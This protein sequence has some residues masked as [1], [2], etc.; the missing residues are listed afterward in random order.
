[1]NIGVLGTGSVGQALA[2]KFVALGHPVRM[3]A[4]EAG[5][6]KAADWAAAA[7]SGASTGT[8]ADAAAFGEL[9]INATAGV[10]SVDAVRAAAA[11]LQGKVLIDVSNPLDFSKGMPPTLFTAAAG[12]SLAERI[13]AAVPEAHV[14]KALNT[15]NASVMVDPGRAGGPTDVFIAGNDSGAKDRVRT[16]LGELGWTAPIDL[17]DLKSARGLEAY[18]LF[19]LQTFIALKTPDFNIRIT[20]K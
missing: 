3:G 6:A 14:V 4:R 12:D 20:K 7:G 5:N 15:M 13:Q 10:G 18:V 17:G 11:G 9:V 1:M 2:G 19:W 16:L 8:F